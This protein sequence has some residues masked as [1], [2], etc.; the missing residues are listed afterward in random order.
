MIFFKAWI[1]NGIGERPLNQ[2]LWQ[3]PDML[4]KRYNAI[5]LKGFPIGE[6][7]DEENT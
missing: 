7:D 1:A 3:D 4:V 5:N 6:E 2:G